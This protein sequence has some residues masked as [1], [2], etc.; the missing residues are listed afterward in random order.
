M[1]C[2]SNS[3]FHEPHI[4]AFN[5]KIGNAAHSRVSEVLCFT[6][7]HKWKKLTTGRLPHEKM[8]FSRSLMVHQFTVAENSA[9]YYVHAVIPMPKSINIIFA[10]CI[11]NDN[12]NFY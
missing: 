7:P 1:W 11:Y 10:E 3:E 5:H 8:H 12:N 2:R 6:K 9:L 4:P